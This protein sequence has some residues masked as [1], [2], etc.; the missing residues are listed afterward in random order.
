[1]NYQRERHWTS[2]QMLYIKKRKKILNKK[3]KGKKKRKRRKEWNPAGQPTF[4]NP[5]Q[6]TRSS[7]WTEK[8]RS[9]IGAILLLQQ[10]FT[11][12]TLFSKHK[13]H[14]VLSDIWSRALATCR[15]TGLPLISMLATGTSA[16]QRQ[17]LSKWMKYFAQKCTEKDIFTFYPRG[18]RR[19][20]DIWSQDPVT[21]QKVRTKTADKRRLWQPI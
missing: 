21:S 8:T 6:K 12:P 17:A 9:G 15:G 3:E 16:L 18:I 19:I 20:S 1:M 2:I 13:P 14:G 4:T 11:E 5:K 7:N 10:R